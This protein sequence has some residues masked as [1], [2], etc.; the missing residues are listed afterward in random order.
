M[1][2]LRMN[3]IVIPL[4][5]FSRFNESSCIKVI[6]LLRRTAFV[7]HCGEATKKTY[8][9]AQFNLASVYLGTP[10]TA[11]QCFLQLDG[12]TRFVPATCPIVSL[13]YR[14]RGNADDD[15][16][17]V[18]STPPRAAPPIPPAPSGTRLNRISFAKAHSAT[19]GL[20]IFVSSHA[21]RLSAGNST[22]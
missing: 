21:C 12:L 7:H 6:D 4:P 18:V 17:V 3:L 2:C 11:F 22:S 1:S 14:C 13:Q 20:K 15:D 16:D 10:F 9:N 5:M 19:T 8:S